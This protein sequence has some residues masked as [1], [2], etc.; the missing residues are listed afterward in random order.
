MRATEIAVVGA[1]PAGLAA[2]AE[3][4]TCGARVALID[5]NR[6]PGGQYF[7]QIA[8]GF[9]RVATTDFDKDQARAESLLRIVAHPAVEYVS[10]STV[11]SMSE[12]SVLSFAGPRQAGRLQAGCVILCTGAYDQPIPFPGWTLP[13]VVTTGGLQNLVKEQRLLPAT[14]AVVAGNGPLLLVAA[15]SLL[16]GGASVAEVLEAAPVHRRILPR[17]GA[18]AAS[19]RILRLA[20]AYRALMMRHGV[21]FSA[22]ETVVEA[23]GKDRLEAVRVAPIDVDGRIQRDRARTIETEILVTG[24]GLRASSELCRIL[25]CRIAHVD[26]R[27]G[28][29]PLRNP[30]LKTSCADVFAA[31]DGAGIGGVELALLEGALAGLVASRRLGRSAPDGGER[32]AQLRRRLARMERF[33]EG[34]EGVYR[35][36]SNYLDLITQ[37]TL[38]CRC[39]EVTAARLGE[40]ASKTDA[41][42]FALKGATRLGMGRC[43]GRFCQSTLAALLAARDNCPVGAVEMPR[44][45]PPAKLVR[46]ADLL[47][48]EIPDPELPADPHLPRGE[49]L[50]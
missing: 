21:C 30:D 6:Q 48:E 44:V 7:R 8:A 19:P 49:M 39:E 26:L 45:R 23:L 25:G 37:E 14:R 33:R 15:G 17:L 9:R 29:L 47:A 2:A 27:G 4:V 46:I 40:L 42:A 24:F 41:S 36:P 34:L 38:I 18:L 11:W 31:G 20:I 10:E 1:G 3:A 43:Q 22:G 13:G 16:R 28:W 32:E 5:D 50:G 35:P 12:T